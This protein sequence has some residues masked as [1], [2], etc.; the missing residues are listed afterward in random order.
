VLALSL[1]L[2][3]ALT[4]CSN[5]STGGGGGGGG[6]DPDPKKT[7]I[8]GVG[9]DGN[10]YNL[11]ITEK[12]AAAK[13]IRAAYAP[14]N[15]DTYVLTIIFADTTK[16]TKISKGT[17][18]T[19]SASEITLKPESGTAFTVTIKTEN[20]VTAITAI[21]GTITVE[22]GTTVQ[23][24]EKISPAVALIA[25]GWD[26]PGG[27]A[28]DNWSTSVDLSDLISTKPKNKDQ[29][30]IVRVT[31]TS[32]KL[33]KNFNLSLDGYGSKGQYQYLGWSWT[34]DGNEVLA[35]VPFDK[36]FTLLNSAESINDGID[37]FRIGI[38]NSVWYR[39]DNGVV[40]Y[41]YGRLPSDAKKGETVMAT[42]RDFKITVQDGDPGVSGGE[43]GGDGGSSPG[44]TSGGSG[45]SG[46]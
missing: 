28:G 14:K 43:G 39:N 4:S 16:G 24:P 29:T 6:G 32:D 36:T 12:V 37:M 13:S 44:G 25:S 21:T 11:E 30:F 8:T 42:I 22:G 18:Q 46:G 40:E 26:N 17:V 19:S 5:G 31:G 15:G 41:D 34:G 45:S 33:L 23:P 10:T 7:V 9:G 27:N 3:L 1:I 20:G 38:Q 2:T 35:N